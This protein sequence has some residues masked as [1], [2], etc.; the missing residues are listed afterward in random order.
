MVSDP[1]L[2]AD[3]D[4]SNLIG[5]RLICTH[6]CVPPQATLLTAARACS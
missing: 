6:T 2:P 5:C 4:T 3:N 1:D